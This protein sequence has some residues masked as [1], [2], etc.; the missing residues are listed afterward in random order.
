MEKKRVFIWMCALTV[1]AGLVNALSIR[2]FATTVSHV[3]GI[4]SNAAISVYNGSHAHTSWLL[5]IIGAFLV[6][7]LISAYITG[8]RKFFLKRIYGYIVIAIG[9]MLFIGVHTLSH[10]GRTIICLFAFLM[11]IQNGM[12]VSFK[13]VLVRMTHMTGYL[14][15]LGVYIG[16]RLRGEMKEDIWMGIVPASG[17]A[18]FALGGVLGLWMFSK[19]GFGAYDIT[20]AAYIFLGIAYLVHQKQSNDKNLDDI[21]DE[22]QGFILK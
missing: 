3:T 9:V 18:V 13:G 19:I 2:N 20:A 15:D 16:Y 1:L 6:G 11:G 22:E 7:A 12:I 4:V 5:S 8:E 10:E 14:T 21:P 17:L